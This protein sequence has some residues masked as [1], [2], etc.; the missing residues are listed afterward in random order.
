MA[1]EMIRTPVIPYKSFLQQAPTGRP[2]LRLIDNSKSIASRIAFQVSREKAMVNQQYWEE[3]LEKLRKGGGGGGGSSKR[4]DRVAV[5]MQLMSFLS[6]KTIQAMLRNFTDNFLG[7][8]NNLSNQLQILNQNQFANFV[9]RIGS[10]LSIGLTNAMSFVPRIDAPLGRLYG[11]VTQGLLLFAL[12]FSFQLNKL[13]EILEEDLKEI[14][15]KL[16]IKEKIRKMKSVLFDFFVE[17]KEE[18]QFIIDSI[19]STF[20]RYFNKLSSVN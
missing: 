4:F 12:A 3:L 2:N 7:Q 16:D 19:K 5:S 18:V 14:L 11:A 6:N 10:M 15:K 17:M 1:V 13:K 9:Q 20:F 8:S